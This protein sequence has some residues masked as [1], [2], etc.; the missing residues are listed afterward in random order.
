MFDEDIPDCYDPVYQAER[1]EANWD[2]LLD[3]LPKCGCCGE[4]I[5]PGSRFWRLWV[6]E[7][8]IN[9]CAECKGDMENNEECVEDIYA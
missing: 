7:N 9:V 4:P 6:K 1:R 8:L 2:R 5:M 3:T